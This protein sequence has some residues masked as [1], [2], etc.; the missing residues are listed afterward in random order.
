M[1]LFAAMM[2]I[3][4]RSFH[5]IVTWNSPECWSLIRSHNNAILCARSNSRELI[6]LLRFF[7]TRKY[8]RGILKS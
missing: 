6:N 5:I 2:A 1:D 4:G 8:V 7:F 3:G